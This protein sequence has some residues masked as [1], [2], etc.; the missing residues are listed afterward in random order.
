MSKRFQQLITGQNGFKIA[1]GSDHI[2]KILLWST[3]KAE[4]VRK[5]E[6]LIFE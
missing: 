5:Q 1:F 4:K 2:N 3:S 6:Q